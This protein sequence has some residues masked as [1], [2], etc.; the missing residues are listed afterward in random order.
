MMEIIGA[1]AAFITIFMF[2]FEAGKIYSEHKKNNRHS[3][4]T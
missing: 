3:D 2:G 1:I 4:Q